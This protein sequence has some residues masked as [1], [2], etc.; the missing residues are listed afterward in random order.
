MVFEKQRLIVRWACYSALAVQGK[1]GVRQKDG[2]ECK[3]QTVMT[4]KPP[5]PVSFSA[6][7]ILAPSNS[8][9]YQRLRD[10]L[11]KWKRIRW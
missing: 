1:T 5:G 2:R 10:G 4:Q 11:N 8:T 9:K 7:I 6:D 3:G